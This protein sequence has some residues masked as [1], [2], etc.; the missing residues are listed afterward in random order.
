MPIILGSGRPLAGRIRLPLRDHPGRPVEARAAASRRQRA[1]RRVRRAMRGRARPNAR[2]LQDCPGLLAAPT[3]AA[4]GAAPRQAR[5][6]RRPTAPV[7]TRS[8]GSAGA[9]RAPGGRLPAPGRSRTCWSNTVR[10]V[11]DLTLRLRV[12]ALMLG[13]ASAVR[14]RRR[15]RHHAGHPLAAGALRQPPCCRRTALLQALADAEDQPRRTRGFRAFHRASCTCRCPGTI[16]PSTRPSRR[17]MDSVRADAPW[18]PDNIEFIRRINGLDSRSTTCDASSSMRATW[19]WDWATSIW[20]RRWRRPLDPRH[21]LVT[22][23]YNPARTWTPPNVVGIGGAYLCIYGMEGPGGYQLFGR[24]IQVWNTHGRSPSFADGKPW[25]LRFFDQIRFFPVSHDELAEWRRDFPFGRRADHDRG[26]RP[27]AWPT[28]GASWTTM[29][30]ASS[31]FQERRQRGL[32]GRAGAT[33]SAATNSR[34]P[35]RSRGAGG[36]PGGAAARRPR[37]RRAGRGAA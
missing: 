31:A 17:Y 20:A 14:A 16:R 21:R 32:R 29:P 23:K 33:G 9:G 4:R 30:T 19:S 24:T 26:R 25:L 37:R 22:T 28:T 13:A 3:R 35:T 11:L 12:H 15:P 36:T 2:G 34:A 8:W 10:I 6:R 1:S 27:S 18:C 5:R 7:L